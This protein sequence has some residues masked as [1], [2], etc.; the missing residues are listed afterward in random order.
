[1]T[2][3]PTPPLTTEAEILDAARSSIP[4]QA[5]P[6][7]TDTPD[8]TAEPP[9][10]QPP[11]SQQTEAASEAD[12]E[13]QG[14]SYE[15]L[16]PTLAELAAQ[17]QYRELAALA[18]RGE[19][20]GAKGNDLT[21]MYVVAP[22]ILAYLIL[23]DVAAAR[24]ALTRLPNMYLRLPV[25]N[26]LFGILSAVHN[27]QHE[28][29]Y[30]S[31]EELFNLCHQPSLSNEKLGSVLAEMTKAFIDAFRSKTFA[32]LG[33]A[34]TSISAPLA[35]RYLG[36]PI[37]QILAVAANNGW[38]YDAAKQVLT[39]PRNATRTRVMI[40]DPSTLSTLGAVVD[41]ISTA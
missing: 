37:D 31:A 24:H 7:A 13:P 29:V 36:L 3:P 17:E 23:D 5:T 11:L 35:Q 12:V 25:S 27:R 38:A 32:L 30:A 16:F 19:A 4:P 8:T 40:T 9:A 18:E 6:M 1:M 2:G 39:P 15:L 10:E 20:S 14:T 33:K 21:R 22:L 28:T 41:T 26:S 34:Y